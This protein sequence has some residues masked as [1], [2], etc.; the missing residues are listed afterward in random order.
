V[1]HLS[2]G[3][4]LKQI[5]AHVH[6][7]ESDGEEHRR[8]QGAADGRS[9]ILSDHGSLWAQRHDLAR[10]NR[11]NLLL[12]R[13]A[14]F[15]LPLTSYR[16]TESVSCPGLVPLRSSFIPLLNVACWTVNVVIMPTV[17]HRG[18]GVIRHDAFFLRERSRSSSGSN[19]ALY[20]IQTAEAWLSRSHLPARRRRAPCQME[21]SF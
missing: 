17:G 4:Q 9:R 7:H 3:F 15:A 21:T 18:L 19:V 16:T 20:R 8:Y 14:P 2:G 6:P 11:A 5:T 1:V 10:R 13:P 12:N